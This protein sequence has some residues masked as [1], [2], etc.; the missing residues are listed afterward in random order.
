[1]SEYIID[2]KWFYFVDLLSDLECII[3][4]ITGVLVVS[5]IIIFIIAS[6]KIFDGWSDEE[7]ALGKALAKKATKLCIIPICMIFIIVFIPSKETMYEMMIA[8][9]ITHENL[10]IS[11]EAVK[12]AVDYIVE[13]FKAV[14]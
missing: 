2:P 1:M 13:A 10:S 4:I 7:R 3:C 11:V 14:N 6:T 9:Y 12:S 8:K 5:I